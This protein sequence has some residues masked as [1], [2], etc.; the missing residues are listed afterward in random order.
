MPN[1]DNYEYMKFLDL[2]GAQQI[3]NTAKQTF[4]QTV[5][6]VGIDANGNVN[7]SGVNFPVG[8][9]YLTTDNST[10]PASLFGGTWERIKD[11][12]LLG[13]GDTYSNGDTGGEAT[14]TLTENEMPIHRHDM[15]SANSGNF[16][17]NV[18]L[19]SSVW[20]GRATL[21]HYI[22]DTSTTSAPVG[23]QNAGGSQAHNNMPP[24]LVVYMWKRVS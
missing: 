18:V 23:I 8:Y 6:G 9:I 1:N 4:V 14:H 16:S 21:L 12:F 13:A 24:Y 19:G 17:D 10:S 7:T 2:T 22:P 5:N 11:R 20:G 15:Y 3:W